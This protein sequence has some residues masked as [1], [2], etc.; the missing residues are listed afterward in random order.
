M[1]EAVKKK[2]EKD[3]S[4]Q[5]VTPHMRDYEACLLKR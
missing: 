1:P 2:I 5:P 4:K 3:L